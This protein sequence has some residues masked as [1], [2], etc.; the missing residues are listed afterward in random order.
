MIKLLIEILETS[1]YYLK[2]EIISELLVQLAVLTNK[3][4]ERKLKKNEDIPELEWLLK[5]MEKIVYKYFYNQNDN[6]V[7][8]FD[9]GNLSEHHVILATLRALKLL[10]STPKLGFHQELLE[11]L[12]S[13]LVHA[14]NQHNHYSDAHLLRKLISLLL[15]THAAQLNFQVLNLLLAHL[16]LAITRSQTAL[17][18][19]II[20]KYPV[21][22]QIN[23]DLKDP[24]LLAQFRAIDA[25]F[26]SIF[27]F[28]RHNLPN[29]HLYFFKK[30]IHHLFQHHQPYHAVL[31][32]LYDLSQ[33]RLR[34]AS[35]STLFNAKLAYFNHYLTANYQLF[36]NH[37]PKYN[38]NLSKALALASWES[39]VSG[40]ALIHPQTQFYF[41]SIYR[42]LYYFWAPMV[43]CPKMEKKFKQ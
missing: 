13:V 12:V 39:I 8:Y 34:Y 2:S 30:H 36:A 10:T 9:F 17:I 11:L 29:L 31:T 1:F 5:M 35:N 4:I 23:F 42:T 33:D 14:D 38:T 7:K 25:H 40:I 27:H 21:F 16:K 26:Q 3:N 28:C 37:Y 6:S 41:T 19:L 24:L 43:T 18:G 32:L 22:V 20:H 15:R